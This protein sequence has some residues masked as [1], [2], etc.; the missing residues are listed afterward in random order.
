M[1][2]MSLLT[3]GGLWLLGSVA[4]GQ[5]TTTPPAS[6]AQA[7]K[8]SPAATITRPVALAE[9]CELPDTGEVPFAPAENELQVPEH[10]RLESHRFEFETKVLRKANRVRA[11]RVKFP[12]A[13]TT[14]VP[15]NN[16][17]HG[18]YFQPAGE[19]PYPACVVLHILGGDFLL[20][21]AVANHL[22]SNGVAALFMKMPYYGE[23]RGKQSPRRM[24][25]E[26]PYQTVEGMTQ[27]VLDIRRASAWLAHRP[28]VDRERLGITGIS[29]GGIMSA[30][31]AEG[32]PRLRNVG[33]VLGG[34]NFAQVVW[35]NDTRQARE[36]RD[37]WLQSGKTKE[38]FAKVL[39]RVDPVT[40]GDKLK[41]RRVLMIAAKNDE[42]VLPECTVALHEAIGGEPEL[43]WLDAGH[44]TAA[45]Y[46]PRE[47]FRLSG[48]FTKRPE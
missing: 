9:W 36:F 27:A 7:T 48:F 1:R 35:N 31:G 44:Y 2:A 20:A 46:L 4:W 41:G 21:E 26:D 10:F 23:R 33:I 42:I 11:A 19:G 3:F 25:S 47:L 32:E 37:R 43:V 16:S 13:V 38:D 45:Q 28:E 24:I 34:G 5:A 40:Y 30:L 29:L 12:S 15:E 17:V 8:A 39:A 22:A 14:E 6:G 18:V